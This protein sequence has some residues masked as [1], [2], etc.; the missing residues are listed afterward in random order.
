MSS[1]RLCVAPMMAYTDRHCR[2]LH[3]LLAPSARLYTE[4]VTADAL[5]HGGVGTRLAFDGAERPVACQ[6]GGGEPGALAQAARLAAQAGFDEVNLNVGCPSER[7]RNRAIGACLMREPRRVAD[8]VAAMR[9]AVD[10]PITV[11]CRVGAV[12]RAEKAGDQAGD[13]ERLRDF[14]GTVADAGARVFIVHG[15]KAVLRGLTPAQNRSV[16]PLRPRWVRRLK[17]DF[18]KL[19]VVYNGGVRDATA[20]TDCLRWA[21]GVMVGRAAYRNPLWFAR[22]A[23]ELLGDPPTTAEQIF[24]AYL[25]YVE[26]Q[27]RAGL[28]LHA[29]SRHL[30]G[31]FSGR[32]GARRYRQ[33]LAEHDRLPGA[34]VDTLR[35]GRALVRTPQGAC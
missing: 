6:L 31:L 32:P 27:L 13:Y 16:P 19:R 24:S 30:H 22:L 5:L 14:V 7:V 34:G 9:A 2:Y 4:M 25:P 15:R 35:A 21:D 33:Y 23:G 8:C 20:A 12:E 3:R 10:V 29:M 17:R 26:R 1:H 11:K 28:P 18:P